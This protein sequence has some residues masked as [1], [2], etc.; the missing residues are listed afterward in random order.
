[1][2]NAVD[3]TDWGVISRRKRWSILA[4]GECV[5]CLCRI[6]MEVDLEIPYLPSPSLFSFFCPLFL[7]FVYKRSILSICNQSATP[8]PLHP[9]FNLLSEIAGSEEAEREIK[10]WKNGTEEGLMWKENVRLAYQILNGILV[11]AKSQNQKRIDS[12]T[13]DLI[14]QDITHWGE[15]RQSLYDYVQKKFEENR[16]KA[17]GL[18]EAIAPPLREKMAEL[19]FLIKLIKEWGKKTK[20]SSVGR[21]VDTLESQINGEIELLNQGIFSLSFADPLNVKGACSTSHSG[22]ELALNMVKKKCQTLLCGAHCKDSWQNKIH[23]LSLALSDFDQRINAVVLIVPT[24]V[25]T[26]PGLSDDTKAD[27]WFQMFFSD[28]AGWNECK[29]RWTGIAL[30]VVAEEAMYP[31]DQSRCRLLKT[32]EN[33]KKHPVDQSRQRL[34]EVTENIAEAPLSCFRSRRHSI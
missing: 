10:K 5:V 13:L 31:V 1:M 25:P 23:E 28:E 4:A 8:F 26:K 17:V 15:V 18:W 22:L 21:Q 9:L 12:R 11:R 16:L 7:F 32:I 2:I 6:V 27:L 14:T 34:L 24:N 3:L 30:K 20:D 19:H 29:E 33:M